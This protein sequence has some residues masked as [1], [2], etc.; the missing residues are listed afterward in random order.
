MVP[1]AATRSAAAAPS[2]GPRLRDP[3]VSLSRCSRCPATGR[4]RPGSY[5][6]LLSGLLPLRA[7]PVLQHRQVPKAGGW[8]GRHSGLRDAESSQSPVPSPARAPPA[9]GAV[10]RR[11]ED[12]SIPAGC[13]VRARRLASADP[14][15][16]RR[17]VLCPQGAPA[18]REPAA[19]N[20]LMALIARG[21][22]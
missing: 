3:A 16:S 19:Y 20:V 9:R 18:S 17:Q 13:R 21:D 8:G 15:A 12:R 14:A 11:N 10:S 1:P 7:A 22:G 4:S 5:R 2:S 6:F